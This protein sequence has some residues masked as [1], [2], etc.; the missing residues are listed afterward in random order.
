MVPILVTGGAGFIGSCFVREWIAKEDTPLVNFDS[1]TY[2]GNLDSLTSV[3]SHPQHIFLRADICDRAAVMECLTRHRPRAIVHF[4]AESHVDRSIDGPAAFVKT[5]V[6]GTCELLEAV[7]GYWRNLREPDRSEFRFLYVS[8][9]EIYGSAGVD[10]SFTESNPCLPNSPYAASKAAAGHFV[11]AYHRTYGLPVLTTACSNNFGPYQFPEKLI[12]LMVL[13]ALEGRPLPIYGDGQ[14]VRDWLFV[15][16]HC[17]ALRLV[18]ADGR[19]GETYNIGGNCLRTNLELVQEICSTVDHLRPSLPHA[20]TASLVR[21]VED[22]AGHDRRYAVDTTKTR[23]ELG[24]QPRHGFDARLHET[25]RWYLENGTWVRRVT[26]GK[27]QR[28]RL[29][30]GIQTAH[31][32]DST[33]GTGG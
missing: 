31:A 15:E 30:I 16:D 7:C 9:D 12:P 20:P 25:I 23:Q 13:N 1:L 4:A 8:T 10:E 17:S 26:T 21:F 28:Q 18:L 6:T 11:R 27:Y 32:D 22:R 33:K 29:G 2:A 5:N 14:Q 24:W 3:M 19:P